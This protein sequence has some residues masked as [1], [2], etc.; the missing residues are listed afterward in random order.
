M[1]NGRGSSAS[2]T[3]EHDPVKKPADT[4]HVLAEMAAD[5][6]SAQSPAWADRW[7]EIGLRRKFLKY[8]HRQSRRLMGTYPSFLDPLHERYLQADALAYH[9]QHK[10]YRTLRWMFILGFVAAVFF[11]V[12]AHVLPHFAPAS[13]AIPAVILFF[14][15]SLWGVIWGL[16]WRSQ[17]GGYQEKFRGYRALAEGLRVQFFWL[18][19]GITASIGEDFEARDSDKAL[20]VLGVIEH[21]A[22]QP[23]LELTDRPEVEVS[24]VT[25]S[26]LEVMTRWRTADREDVEQSIEARQLA[27]VHWVEG[28]ERYFK[29]AGAREERTR[30]RWK[31][32]EWCCFGIALFL[33]LCLMLWYVASEFDPKHLGRLLWYVASKVDP[34]HLGRLTMIV[35]SA[36]TMVAAGL[37]HG[38]IEKRAFG[39]HSESYRQILTRVVHYKEVLR[40]DDSD[41]AKDSLREFGKM[42]LRENG[43]WVRLHRW[44]P[45][46]P[47]RG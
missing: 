27:L 38:Y 2:V 5:W 23:R 29:N 20:P 44:R 7:I 1:S 42:A 40:R 24:I 12:N 31:M 18:L 33:P 9:Y 17:R 14:Y 35:V 13:R 45:L 39:E 25:N 41:E 16:Y 28:Q 47:P 8:E 6:R 4:A 15:L 21:L 30:N 19:G 10:T 34:K 43:D 11:E 46:E 36:L 26:G 37:I 22:A 32:L 3:R